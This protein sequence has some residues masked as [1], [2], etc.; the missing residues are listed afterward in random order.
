MRH[1]WKPRVD[2]ATFFFL[3]F[4]MRE[5]WSRINLWF[6]MININPRKK[7]NLFRWCNANFLLHLWSVGQWPQV[8][9]E[10][11]GTGGRMPRM[12]GGSQESQA[13]KWQVCVINGAVTEMHEK[14]VRV[15]VLFLYG[16]K[17]WY[18]QYL[19]V[20]SSFRFFLKILIN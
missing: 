10:G 5:D 11:F 12:S 3:F 14:D 15:L 1:H 9:S 2:S 18:Y 17:Y 8:Y 7:E 4:L 19:L 16:I 13:I 6:L 20:S